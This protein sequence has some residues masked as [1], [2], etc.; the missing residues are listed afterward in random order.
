M[1]HAYMTFFALFFFR[2]QAHVV[3]RSNYV[4]DLHLYEGSAKRSFR[5]RSMKPSSSSCAEPVQPPY[6]GA[7]TSFRTQSLMPPS[8]RHAKPVQ[9]P[10]RC[11]QHPLDNKT[12]S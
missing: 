5:A 8:S 4:D 1:M 11:P 2:M 10:Q 7:K 9:P 12:N 6:E 3:Q